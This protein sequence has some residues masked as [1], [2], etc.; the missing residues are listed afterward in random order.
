MTVYGIEDC[1]AAS[2]DGQWFAFDKSIPRGR[3][4]AIMAESCMSWWDAIHCYT[5]RAG[6][7]HR[8]AVNGPGWWYE[9]APGCECSDCVPVWIVRGRGA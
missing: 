2:E 5:I 1:K 4:M 6:F 3:V 8:D 7:I 9:A